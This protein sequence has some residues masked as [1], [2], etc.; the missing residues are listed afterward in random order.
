MPPLLFWL[1]KEACRIDLL[2]M[3]IRMYNN[4]YY[5]CAYVVIAECC[6]LVVTSCRGYV[7]PSMACIRKVNE[8]FSLH[9]HSGSVVEDYWLFC[10][11][12]SESN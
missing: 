10:I 6:N 11:M 8:V 2:D 5:I 1:V 12:N 3:L 4:I 7:P 9:H